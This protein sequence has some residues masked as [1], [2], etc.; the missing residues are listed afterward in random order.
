M[1]ET[2]EE[3]EK[4]YSSYMICEYK[5]RNNRKQRIDLM[6][7][8]VRLT[9]Q[10]SLNRFSLCKNHLSQTTTEDKPGA[11]YF[12]ILKSSPFCFK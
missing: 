4:A 5:N 1:G 6:N 7:M 11:Q 10:E 8:A 2:M 9:S 12:N 3:L